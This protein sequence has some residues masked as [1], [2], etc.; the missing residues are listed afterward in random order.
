M[1]TREKF[2]LLCVLNS[3]RGTNWTMSLLI[4]VPCLS[5]SG[6]SS[7]SKVSWRKDR[8]YTYMWTYH[9]HAC[10]CVC[11]RKVVC[12]HKV[13]VLTMFVKSA[14]PTPTM[15]IESGS[16]EAATTLSM[17]LSISVIT[18]SYR[19]RERRSREHCSYLTEDMITISL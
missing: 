5:M 4:L 2:M 14:E 8:H 7:A 16:L 6:L 9:T 18:P 13:T 10:V 1:R 17:V 11:V 3:L 15:T 19:Q 12:T